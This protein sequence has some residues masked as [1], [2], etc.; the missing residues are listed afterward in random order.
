MK[1]ML[2]KLL[3]VSGLLLLLGLIATY[4]LSRIVIIYGVVYILIAVNEIVHSLLR[5][6][7]RKRMF[8]QAQEQAKKLN[9]PLMVIG[10]P[11]NGD[12][13]K[14]HGAS[15]SC[16]DICVD[17]TGCPECPNG[18]KAKLPDGLEN[19]EDN[20]H[21]VFVS[22]VLE[23]VDDYKK[24]I[25]EIKRIGG[26]NVYALTLSPYQLTSYLYKGAKNVFFKKPF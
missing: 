12:G 23:Y 14:I 1:S 26:D 18:L 6:V 4:G 11:N 16:G 2:I 3:L 19:I 15:Y 8:E 20:S 21:V 5:Q 17:L 13:S 22:Y 10:D 9:K 7:H 24:A 25:D